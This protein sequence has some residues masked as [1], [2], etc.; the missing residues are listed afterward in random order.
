VGITLETHTIPIY[1]GQKTI[2]D[3]LGLMDRWGFELRL[4][5]PQDSFDGVAVEYNAYFTRR[6]HCLPEP[7]DLSLRKLRLA[8]E[9]WGLRRSGL[10]QQLLEGVLGS[11]TPSVAVGAGLSITVSG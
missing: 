2:G 10:G 1:E 3:I 5:Q 9:V 4:L 6:L 8:E 7:V 11:A